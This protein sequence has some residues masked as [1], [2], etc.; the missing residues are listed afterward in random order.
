MALNQCLKHLRALHTSI[1]SQRHV[2][3]LAYEVHGRVRPNSSHHDP[4]IFLHGFLG[5]KR[6]NRRVSRLLAHDLSR[7]VFAL[8]LRNHGDSAH[9]PIHN[10]MAMALDVESFIKTHGLKR[11]TLIGHS[12]GAKTALALALHSPAMISNVIAVDNGPIRL[13]IPAEFQ[14]YLVALAKVQQSQIKSHAEGDRILADYEAASSRSRKTLYC[15]NML[16]SAAIRLWLLS[17]FIKD[18]H[19]SYLKL[20]LPLDILNT[21]L[22]PLGDFPYMNE[23]VKFHRPTLFLRAHQSHYIPDHALPRVQNFFP[24][25]RVVDMDCGHWIVQDR[26]EEF[27]QGKLMPLYAIVSQ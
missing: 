3:P 2:V 26:P 7:P 13:P 14:R 21:A 17:N 4:I 6:E 5:S 24:Q 8:D 23:P 16:Q 27:R 19:E 11:A 20:R 25:A 12:M 15:V 1:P 22:G 18:R 10:Y 9:H